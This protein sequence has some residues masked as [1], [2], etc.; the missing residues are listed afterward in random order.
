MFPRD[1]QPQALVDLLAKFRQGEKI[2]H[3]VKLQLVAGAKIALSWVH[4]HHPTLDLD[5]VSSWLPPSCDGDF[6][7]M[8]PHYAAARR[9]AIRIIRKCLE[10]DEEV[11]VNFPI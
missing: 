2:H 6:I 10:A 9:P 7:D 5:D 11:F 1:L 3:F 4:V 8:A